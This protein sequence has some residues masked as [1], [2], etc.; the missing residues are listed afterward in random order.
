MSFLCPQPEG[1]PGSE[2]TVDNVPRL[3]VLGQLQLS[4]T[5]RASDSAHLILQPQQSLELP[6]VKPHNHF[7]IYHNDWSSPAA[8]LLHELLHSSRIF[9]YVAIR[10]R[11]FVIGKKLLRRVTR[12][13]TRS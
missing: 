5:F 3:G 4:P 10:E 6:S 11:D 12:C 7:P 9:H 2:R 13:S 8:D 1:K